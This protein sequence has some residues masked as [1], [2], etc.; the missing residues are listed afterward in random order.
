MRVVPDDGFQGKLLA[1]ICYNEYK[2]QTVATFSTTDQN[3]VD[4]V[5]QF[6]IQASKLGITVLAANQFQPIQNSKVDLTSQINSAKKSGARIFV[7]C[8]D[9][10]SAAQYVHILRIYHY[11]LLLRAFDFKFLLIPFMHYLIC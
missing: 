7:L 8:M 1:S 10:Y 4:Q 11:A 2:W 5:Q 9:S 6:N 3:G